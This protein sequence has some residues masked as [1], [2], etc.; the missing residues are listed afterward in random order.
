[1]P[2]L[3]SGKAAQSKSQFLIAVSN[4]TSGDT[5]GAVTKT[6]RP[7]I[8]CLSKILTSTDCDWL[9]LRSGYDLL[10]H[11][12]GF[13][14]V[15]RGAKSLEPSPCNTITVYP[16]TSNQLDI[17]NQSGFDSMP[18]ICGQCKSSQSKR[19]S[20]SIVDDTNASVGFLHIETVGFPRG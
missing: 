3:N 5:L 15:G 10:A 16:Q 7:T 20:R 14:T 1:M 13:S 11:A 6:Q 8:S 18:Y 2:I 12:K 9:S 19:A 17:S 4:A